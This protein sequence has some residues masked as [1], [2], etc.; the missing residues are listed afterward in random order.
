MKEEPYLARPAEFAKFAAER[1]EMVVVDP[2]Q[3]A[4][5]Q[6]VYE[7]GGVLPVYGAIHGVAVVDDGGLVREA[8]EQRPDGA[9]GEDV[10]EALDFIRGE[11]DGG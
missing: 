9:I 6:Q 7:S 8:V 10:V 1:Q 5:D 3:I 4:G 2:D 11:G